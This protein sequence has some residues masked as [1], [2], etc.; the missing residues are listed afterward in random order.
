VTAEPFPRKDDEAG[1]RGRLRALAGAAGILMAGFI[2]SRVLGL[3]R[4]AVLAG[5]FGDSPQYEAYV[6]AIAVPDAVF[7]VLAG[8]VMGAAFIPVFARY[9]ADGDEEDAWRLGSSAINLAAL[10]TGAI[11]LLLIVFARPVMSVVVSGRDAE[12]QELATGLV[13]IMLVSPVIFA[14]SGFAT[15]I[16]NTYQRFF[17]AALAPLMYNVGIIAGTVL[18]HDRWGIYGV[19]IGVAAGACGHLLIQVPGLLQIRAR[20]RP[21]LDW[22]NAGVR[23]VGKLMLP[24]M[25]G[26][27]VAQANQLIT[28][29]FL[30]SFLVA[31]SMA[32]LNYAWL[33]LMVPLGV[34]GMAVSTAVFPTLARQ[35]AAGEDAEMGELFGLSLRM[36]LYL[37]V[38]AAVGLIVIGEPIVR[39][40]FERASFTPDVTRATALAVAVYALGL[41]GHSV[42]EIVDR[43]FYALHDTRTPVKAAALAVLLNVLLSAA[44]VVGALRGAVPMERAYAGLALANAIAAWV[45]AGLLVAW[46]HA[47]TGG[48]GLRGLGGD[49]LR[50]LAAALLMGGLLVGLDDLLLGKLDASRLSG[51][52]AYVGTLIA[53]GLAAYLLCS[54]LLHSREPRLLLG[55]LRRR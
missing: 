13:R 32:Y 43:A 18:L 7:Q 2:A 9:L 44:V 34:F 29:V 39:L 24:R 36:I 53:V 49:L 14:V 23:E 3:V 19:A 41:P 12:F 1:L 54:V 4:N 20:Y 42:V 30:A 27:G 37:T 25:F 10:L 5:Y 48:L 51:Q 11:A 22:R 15:S 50:Y 17:W 47:R 21:V 33:V 8:G 26:L 55:L 45:E 38:P 28:T 46:L 40:L 35:S 16:L 31:G 6:A 52:L